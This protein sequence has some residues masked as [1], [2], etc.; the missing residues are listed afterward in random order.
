MK[1]ARKYYVTVLVEENIKLTPFIPRYIIGIDLG[2]KDIV[3][4]S[5]KDKFPKLEKLTSLEKKLKGL[6]KW[7]A[8]SKKRK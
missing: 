5:F 2:V 4:T 1:D 8:R 6:N 7:L 3:V